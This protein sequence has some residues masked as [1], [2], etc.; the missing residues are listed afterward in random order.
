[1]NAPDRLVEPANYRPP[2]RIG[3]GI[4]ALL[5][6][7]FWALLLISQK[8]GLQY[9]EALHVA[10]A[11]HMLRG[12]GEFPLTHEPHCWITVGQHSFPLMAL[13]Y[14]GAVKDYF[15][16]PLFAVTGPRMSVIRLASMLLGAAGI[17]GLYILSR[18]QFGPRVAA[19]TAFVL[20][21]NPAYIQQTVFDNSAVGAWMAAFGLICLT[22]NR[23][24]RRPDFR[25][26]VTGPFAA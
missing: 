7:C 11:V 25:R 13:R 20:A 18:D 19:A 8:P 26:R 24:L 14:T 10:G 16:L 21:A 9:D 1:M 15:C 4:C 3:A 23:Y 2:A 6:Y 5:V 22:L 12:V 17:W